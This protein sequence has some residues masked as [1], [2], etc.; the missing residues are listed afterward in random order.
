LNHTVRNIDGVDLICR[1][2]LD[3][4][5][6]KLDEFPNCC[7][8]GE[9]IINTVVPE[10]AL[11][12]R[13]S[14][15]CYIH[16]D[17]WACAE[18]TWDAFHAANSRFHVNLNAIIEARSKLWILKI[19]RM[20]QANIYFRAVNNAWFLFWILKK[21]QIFGGMWPDFSITWADNTTTPTPQGA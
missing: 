16:D 9:G 6:S 21:K 10:Q 20:Y 13:I 18:P 11:W 19:I 7:G 1:S 15:A 14:P 17:D 12:V 8:A 3:I 5:W 2:D 4:P